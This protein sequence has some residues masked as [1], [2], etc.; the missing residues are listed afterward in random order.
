MST[1]KLIAKVNRMMPFEVSILNDPVLVASNSGTIT[2]L[3]EQFTR[4]FQWT[5]EELL[6]QNAHLLIPSK[7]IRKS[8]HDSKLK[9]YV[10]GRESPII[11]KSRIV[12]VSTPDDL[13]ILVN[14]KIIPI[15]HKKEHCFMVLFNVIEFGRR[16]ADFEIEFKSLQTKLKKLNKSEEFRDDNAETN[17]VVKEISRLFGKELETIGD[18]ISEN[19]HTSRNASMCKHFLINAPI[20]KLGTLMKEM[21]RHFNNNHVS[22]LNVTCLRIVFPSLANRVDNQS[23]NAIKQS[24][25][26]DRS[27]E[28]S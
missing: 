25:Y 15:R 20:G 21:D 24:L 6:G 13:E 3:N 17:S 9:G 8:D 7:F 12:P 27:E 18:F 5:K 11:G 26:E 10:F 2:D 14:I 28:T 16:F 1:S 23:L 22:Y 4:V 19:S